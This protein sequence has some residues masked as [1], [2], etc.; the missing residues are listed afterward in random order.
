MHT[1]MHGAQQVVAMHV[2]V[3]LH[4]NVVDDVEKVA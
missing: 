4:E 1:Q 2:K 3:V